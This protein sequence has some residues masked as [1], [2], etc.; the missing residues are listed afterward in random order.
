MTLYIASTSPGKVKEFR[1]SALSYSVIVKPVP[2]IRGLPACVEDGETFEANARKKALH[3]SRFVSGLLMADDS[4]ICVDA[5]E[6]APGVHSARFAGP[7]ADDDENNRLLLRR[8]RKVRPAGANQMVG[9]GTIKRS[10]HY[11]CVIA[12]AERGRILT[13]TKGRSNGLIMETP[14]GSGGFGYD[15]LFYYP[16]LGKSFAEL[17]PETKFGVSHR[18]M[19]FRKLLAYLSRNLKSK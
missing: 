3:Y 2:G 19:A 14:R 18:G 7:S 6:G 12:L 15:P 17:T 4:G 1:E 9:H 11:I 16:P 13:T 10:A 5:L 8:L